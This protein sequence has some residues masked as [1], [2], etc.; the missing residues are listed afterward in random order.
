M[1]GALWALKNKKPIV[2][3]HELQ[4]IPN[5]LVA[6][7]R[8]HLVTKPSL[9]FV[10]KVAKIIRLVTPAAYDLLVKTIP[11]SKH[12]FK[13]GTLGYIETVPTIQELPFDVPNSENIITLTGYFDKTKNIKPI[14]AGFTRLITSKNDAFLIIIGPIEDP[15]I[16]YYIS[17]RKNIIYY[18]KLLNQP[19]L[20][21]LL[22][23]SKINIWSKST[24]TIFE[25]LQ[26]KNF[27]ILPMNDQTSHL[28]SKQIVLLEHFN[29][30][31]IKKTFVNLLNSPKISDNKIYSYDCIVDDLIADYQ[32]LI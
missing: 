28:R 7:L 30:I 3:D 19:M 9:I 8:Y 12:K 16:R 20:N 18:D 25:A 6:K 15:K 1:I 10:I 29:F 4:R 24:S 27:V 31:N 14:I 11:G 2:Y 26:Y 17:L 23:K 5:R 21:F 32:N 22:S 13:L